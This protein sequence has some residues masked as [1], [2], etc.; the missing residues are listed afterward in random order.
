MTVIR[1]YGLT[2]VRQ[3][4]SG[5]LLYWGTIAVCLT[6]LQTRDREEE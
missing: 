6:P 4:S 5:A 1:S 2:V 3:G